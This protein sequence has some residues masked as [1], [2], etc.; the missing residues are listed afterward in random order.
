MAGK[1]YALIIGLVILSCV[2][3]AEQSIDSSTHSNLDEI[4]Q[5]SMNLDILISFEFQSVSG[6]VDINFEVKSPTKIIVLDNS[7]LN[8]N[9]VLDLKS[10]NSL[11]FETKVDKDSQIGDSLVITL[12]RNYKIGEK[13]SL[14]IYYSASKNASS[15]QWLSKEMTFGGKNPF[16]Y[17]QNESI[18][19]RSIVPCQDTPAIK[20]KIKATITTDRSNLTILFGGT[21]TSETIN[22]NGTKTAVFE[23]KNPIPTYLIAIAIGD[24]TSQVIATT[25]VEV[26]VWAEPN[27]VISAADEFKDIQLFIEKANEYSG[28][29]YAWGFYD[30]L[31]LPPAFPFGGME[32]PNLTFVSPSVISGDRSLVNVLAHELAH[33]WTGNLVTNQNWDNFWLNEGFTVFFERKII[34]L[35]R[36]DQGDQIRLI[37]SESGFAELKKDMNNLYSTKKDDGSPDTRFQIYTHLNPQ[38]GK[39]NPDDSSSLVPYEKGYNLLYW[40]EGL[41][42]AENFQI[43]FQEHIKTFKFSTATSDKFKNQ[44]LIENIKRLFEVTPEKR[45]QILGEV[46]DNWDKWMN[47]DLWKE[48]PTV[49][50][51]K[52]LI[53]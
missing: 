12:L 45:D 47:N 29:N 34:Q 4:I 17:T 35:A 36:G 43:V 2:A 19:A 41:L 30:V 46:N 37:S 5:T 52:L 23:Q 18:Y 3:R 9:S 7:D 27:I 53:F 50:F 24:L 25:P 20:L 51:S 8:I 21:K 33:S 1:I 49:D 31:V 44:I 48:L 13:I 10:G 14:S 28:L 32:N 16:Y 26:K 22:S 15:N 40:L 11:A 6:R 38:V 42:G 39:F